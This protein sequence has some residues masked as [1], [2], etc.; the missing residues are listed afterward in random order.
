MTDKRSPADSRKET[1]VT[2]TIRVL[3][4]TPAGTDT[5][6]QDAPDDA[7]SDYMKTLRAHEKPA[8]GV[9]WPW[10][11][12]KSDALY[13]VLS[14]SLCGRLLTSYRRGET[15]LV[16]SETASD[17]G[18]CRPVSTARTRL[19]DAANHSFL[20]S[21]MRAL[22]SLYVDCPLRAAGIFL[23]VYGI[24]G[25]LFQAFAPRLMPEFS[26]DLGRMTVYFIMTILS[27]PLI[28][29]SRTLREGLHVGTFTR[30]V[31][32]GFLG[33]P[34]EEL[35]KRGRIPAAPAILL[36]VLFGAGA[37]VASIRLHPLLIPALI[38][39]TGL[40]IAVL[41]Y[42][43]TGVVLS[44]LCLP[45]SWIGEATLTFTAGLILLTWLSYG[46][47]LLRL[48]R[49]FRTGRL[50]A[51]YGVLMLVVLCGGLFGTSFSPD[52]LR[53]GLLALVLLSDYYLIVNLMKTRA[54]VSRCLV[55]V[56][57]SIVFMTLLCFVRL[58]PAGVFDWM[59]D[60]PGFR[61]LLGDFRSATDFLSGL[62][63]DNF[64]L[65]LILM[66]P[67]QYAF[68]LR[69]KRLGQA[70]ATLVLLALDLW[71]VTMS[72]SVMAVAGV[73]VVFLLFFLLWSRRTP[74]VGVVLLPAAL[75]AG[76]IY[77]A[78]RPLGGFISSVLEVLAGTTAHRT[79][80]WTGVW[81]MIAAWPFGIGLSEN[82][83]RTVYPAFAEPGMAEAVASGSLYLDVLI[84]FGWPGAVV[85]AVA[86]FFFIQKC[87]TALART[88]DKR[89]RALLLGGFVSLAGLLILGIGRSFAVIP[90]PAF[91]IALS[92][93]LCS[94]FA[95]IL[96]DEREV[97]STLHAPDPESADRFYSDGK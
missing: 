76:C 28:V 80:V 40:I 45:F 21:L 36:S 49:T 91:I 53:Q 79:A 63:A 8:R 48:H 41:S 25:I 13:D 38:L 88:Q 81:R 84:A 78:Y 73:L 10:L 68:L 56:G 37:A 20:L 97:L 51:V 71:A 74:A 19:A 86:V 62:W 12:R 90:K 29:T 15:A 23:I 26:F 39:L 64:E 7:R 59:D 72:D 47:S 75:T 77:T 65:F 42:P 1:V 92:V 27:V 31:L 35:Q 67:W 46:V 43:E 32:C 52:A 82:A 50:E 18:A 96:L 33:I 14:H 60:S 16:R 22:A 83:F 9:I 89:D 85:A 55:G 4:E 58:I 24:L 61:E 6:T 5:Q 44:T 94:A 34:E 2:E 17:A 87:M 30:A 95:N 11:C 70:A 57:I 54:Y 69:T 66:L 93:G 3:P